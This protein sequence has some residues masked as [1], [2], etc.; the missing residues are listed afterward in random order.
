MVRANTLVDPPGRGARAVSDP[1]RPL[2]ASLRVPSPPSTTTTSVPSWAAPRARRSA[3]PR[4]LVSARVT[5]KSAARALWITTQAR[6]VTDDAVA[7]TMS[8]MRSGGSRAAL[9]ARAAAARSRRRGRPDGPS[10]S[11]SPSPVQTGAPDGPGGRRDD[12]ATAAVPF[13]HRGL[14]AVLWR[15]PRCPRRRPR[16]GSRAPPGAG[17]EG[18]SSVLGGRVEGGGHRSQ[19]QAT[20]RRRPRPGRPT[21]PTAA[22]GAG[23]AS[24]RSWVEGGTDGLVAGVLARC[25]AG[26]ATCRR[27]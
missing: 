22:P 26:R 16:A 21:D 13:Q 10:H 5:S 9:Q 8:R 23:R 19:S 6:A 17:R 18:H 7:L 1:A 2:A 14:T 15:R 12:S 24:G 20:T 4:R 25:V 11:T 27:R 3:W